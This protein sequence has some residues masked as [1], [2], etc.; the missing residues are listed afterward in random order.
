MFGG[1]VETISHLL[2][3]PPKESLV[4]IFYYVQEKHT[5][6]AVVRDASLVVLEDVV[7]NIPSIPDGRLIKLGERFATL[8]SPPTSPTGYLPGTVVTA[9]GQRY[10]LAKTGDSTYAWRSIQ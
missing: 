8:D 7:I 2:A 10:L 3:S 4:G 9:G 1:S 6:Y 5:F